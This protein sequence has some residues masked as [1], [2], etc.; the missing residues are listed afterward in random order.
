MKTK[1]QKFLV[2]FTRL[3]GDLNFWWKMW[4]WMNDKFIKRERERGKTWGEMLP[5]T[6]LFY[7]VELFEFLN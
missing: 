6:A 1:N 4:E 3:K 5:K 7:Y 2:Q